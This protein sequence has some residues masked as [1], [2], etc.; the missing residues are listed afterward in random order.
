MADYKLNMLKEKIKQF[1]SNLAKMN[2]KSTS[3]C[4]RKFLNALQ[5]GIDHNTIS[6][7]AFNKSLKRTDTNHSNT[8]KYPSPTLGWRTFFKKNLMN[9]LWCSGVITAVS[10]RLTPS[11][12]HKYRRSID[13]WILGLIAI[14]LA[15]PTLSLVKSLSQ[16]STDISTAKLEQSIY[17]ELVSLHSI[18]KWYDAERKGLTVTP[19]T[20]RELAENLFYISTQRQI[21]MEELETIFKLYISNKQGNDENYGVERINEAFIDGL[22]QVVVNHANNATLQEALG[23]ENCSLV[24]DTINKLKLQEGYQMLSAR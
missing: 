18:Y 15:S 17:S 23:N 6:L 16:R 11:L 7:E 2:D 8:G 14:A 22:M 13:T 20:Q 21:T 4:V 9:A 3:I 1:E 10:L 19:S 12:T 5:F 24:L